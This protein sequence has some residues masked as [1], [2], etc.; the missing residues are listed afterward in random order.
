MGELGVFLGALLVGTAVLT[1]AGG[2]ISLAAKYLRR[3]EGR[4]DD[5]EEAVDRLS[6]EVVELR[7]LVDHHDRLLE[8]QRAADRIAP[9]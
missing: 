2:S 9:P 5:L 7:E 8:N 6:A 1:L 4:R 3:W